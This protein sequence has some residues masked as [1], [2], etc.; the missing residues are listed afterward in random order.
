MANLIQVKAMCKAMSELGH[1]VTLSLPGKKPDNI[2]KFSYQINFRKQWTKNK[3]DKYISIIPLLKSI[4]KT[5]PDILFIRDPLIL[6]YAY[7]FSRKQI[8]FETHN[9]I[10][11]Q[12]F[13]S[14]DKFY[15]WLLK[16]SVAKGRVKTLVCI[17]YA[18]AN[19]W[20]HQ[21][22]PAD[23]IVAAHD[24]ID[25]EM[26]NTNK[27]KKQAR[28]ELSLPK[29]KIIATYSGRLY[30]NRKIDNILSLAS[31][32]PE[33]FF[34]VVGGPDSNAQLFKSEAD[35]I[36]LKNILFTGQVKH[37]QV[38]DYLAASDILLALW[39]SDVPTINYCSPLKLFEY[40]AAK[41]IILAHG[42]PTIKE[43]LTDEENSLLVKIDDIDDLIKKLNIAIGL[44]NNTYIPV[45][46]YNEVKDKY[47]WKKRVESILDS[48]TH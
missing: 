41:K 34:V 35:E 20:K 47:T 45:N 14:L 4:K 24:G 40:M 19:Y 23:K 42:F 32:F 48:I 37:E 2:A 11:H 36:H 1:D 6:L 18:L 33:A 9:Y 29:D 22:I 25:I 39:S 43:V 10:L 46:A 27:T 28:E 38:P 16:K 21:G 26:F 12:G 13:K 3:L 7:L 17:S 31:K 30:A 8:I 44:I 5:K 15:H